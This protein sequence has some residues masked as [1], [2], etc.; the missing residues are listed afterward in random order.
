MPPPGLAEGAPQVADPAVPERVRALAGTLAR[1]GAAAWP[2]MPRP[3]TWTDA[4]PFVAAPVR[5]PALLVAA[6]DAAARAGVLVYSP[7]SGW[8]L[9][10]HDAVAR[11]LATAVFHDV[12]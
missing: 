11:E 5:R 1:E 9:L 3:A 8:V 10:T 12:R 4:L 2:V 6:T 7:A